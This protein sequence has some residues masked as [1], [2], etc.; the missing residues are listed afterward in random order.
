MLL[1][2]PTPS[3]LPLATNDSVERLRRYFPPQCPPRSRILEIAR[4]AV[5]KTKTNCLDPS[6]PLVVVNIRMAKNKEY[7]PNSSVQRYGA[8]FSNRSL[9]KF[10]PSKRRLDRPAGISKYLLHYLC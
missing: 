9:T 2:S 8:S 5:D 4:C 3:P 10:V 7:S 1:L 6:L